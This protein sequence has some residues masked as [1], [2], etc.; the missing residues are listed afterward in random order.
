MRT[1]YPLRRLMIF[2][3]WLTVYF[4][5]FAMVTTMAN[6]GSKEINRVLLSSTIASIFLFLSAFTNL[7]L[8]LIFENKK[9]KYKANITYKFLILSY[10]LSILIFFTVILS[11]AFYKHTSVPQNT[12]IY[13]FFICILI[14]TL[15]LALQR[16]IVIQDLK[17]KSDL[18]NSQLKTINADAANQILRQ[19]I[20]P[21]FLFNALNILKSLY[22]INPKAGEEYLIR[23]S[24]F[25]RASVTTNNIKI[26][27]VKDE[28]KLC[29]DYLE[30]QKIRFGTALNYSF[31]IPEETLKSYYLPSFSI[32]PLLENAIKHNELTEES[33]LNINV[34]QDGGWIKVTNSLK[35]KK[36]TEIST[37]SGLSN[38]SERY[39][40]LANEDIIIKEE[41]DSFVVCIKLL[42]KDKA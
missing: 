17:S 24:D 16:S 42:S 37:G 19:Q 31:S 9:E 35:I 20:H 40:L 22:R 28:V 5:L 32:Q 26:I 1:K 33:P 2:N 14:N 30:M 13:V 41:N 21:H 6:Y 27:P 12:L 34:S 7:W 36:N 8:M 3:L 29:E 4:F 23:L 25:L 11:Y 38:L 10:L 18:E 15:V 39:K